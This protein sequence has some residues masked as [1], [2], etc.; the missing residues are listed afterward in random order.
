MPDGTVCDDGNAATSNDVCTGGSVCAGTS[1]ADPC[2]PEPVPERRSLHLRTAA[3]VTHARAPQAWTGT[4]CDASTCSAAPAGTNVNGVV[5]VGAGYYRDPDPDTGEWY[6]LSGASLPLTRGNTYT[7]KRTTC[8]DDACR[9]HP[10]QIKE[11]GVDCSGLVVQE[12]NEEFTYTIPTTGTVAF[13]C[14][15]HPSVT[16]SL[17]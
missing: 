2:D 4:N 17:V 8:G 3:G 14:E 6:D 16:D 12:V 11:G 9:F 5:E 7:F 10:F 15:K 1:T 13:V